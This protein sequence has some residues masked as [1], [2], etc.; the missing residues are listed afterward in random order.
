M[1]SVCM[2]SRSIWM[3]AR[4]NQFISWH[5][6][7]DFHE[8]IWNYTWPLQCNNDLIVLGRLNADSIEQEFP[9]L[10]IRSISWLWDTPNAMQCI[11][12]NCWSFYSYILNR[13]VCTYVLLIGSTPTQQTIGHW[14]QAEPFLS[15]GISIWHFQIL[16][17]I[18]FLSSI[19]LNGWV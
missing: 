17:H 8:V 5:W 2:D 18:R 6:N 1:H 12:G 7:S 11:A 9:I 10:E 15:L 16:L 14:T 19:R 3:P 4:W 13:C